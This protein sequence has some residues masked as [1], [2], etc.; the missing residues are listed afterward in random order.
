MT[1]FESDDVGSSP[2]YEAVAPPTNTMGGPA[3]SDWADNL[4]ASRAMGVR[5]RSV[6]PGHVTMSIDE[7]VWPLNP[8]GALHGGLVVAAADH[9]MGIAAMTVQAEGRFTA[10]ASLTTDFHLPAFPPVT[11]EAKVARNGRALT[12]VEL[13]AFDASGR[14]CGGATG[15]WAVNGTTAQGG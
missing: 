10:T 12:F 2:D 4:P 11:L 3:W 14:R 8:N 5:C 1:Y 9:C 6:E 15:V 13:S 7:S